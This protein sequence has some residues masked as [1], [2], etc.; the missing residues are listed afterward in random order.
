MGCG[1]ST[2]GVYRPGVGPVTTDG[3]NI[4]ALLLKLWAERTKSGGIAAISEQ[5]LA[6]APS[7]MDQVELYLP[8]FAHIVTMLADEIA[9]VD[10]A[11]L[12]HFLL[13]VSQLS[14]HIVRAAGDAPPR[15]AWGK[16][17]DGG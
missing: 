12:E 8:Q 1:S 6:V 4:E 5:M 9:P 10:V 11:A 2:A 15:G 13:S 14:I 16:G 17:E 3:S 7:Q